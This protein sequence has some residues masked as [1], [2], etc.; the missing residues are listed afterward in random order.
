MSMNLKVYVGPYL[1]LSKVLGTR[2]W[3]D[4]AEDMIDV[5]S[6]IPSPYEKSGILIPNQKIKNLDTCRI[7]EDSQFSSFEL[8]KE[9]I[10]ADVEIFEKAMHENIKHIANNGFAVELKYGLH[11]FVM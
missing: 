11:S 6:E 7:D 10:L 5:L 8:T 4:G 9:K 3:S 2:D 1:K